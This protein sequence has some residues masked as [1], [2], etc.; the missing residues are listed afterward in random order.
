M[1]VPAVQPL[2]LS[3]LENGVL[4]LTLNRPKAR[5]ALSSALMAALKTALEGSRP[6]G[7]GDRDRRRGTDLLLWP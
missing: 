4:R 7:A 2:L 3:T 1:N 5:N 6:H